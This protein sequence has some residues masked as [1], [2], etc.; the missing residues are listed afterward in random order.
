M[1]DTKNFEF[2]QTNDALAELSELLVKL[3]E[4]ATEKKKQLVA[5]DTTQKAERF[6]IEQRLELLRASSQNIINNVDNVITKLD[7]VLV[8]DGTS[9][10]NN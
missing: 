1:N 9:N 4:S 7:K 3:N 2:K 8:N 5:Q 6:E 10:N